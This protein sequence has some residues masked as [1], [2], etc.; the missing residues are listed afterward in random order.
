LPGNTSVEVATAL[1]VLS[2]PYGLGQGSF[3]VGLVT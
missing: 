3:R 2:K 1:S